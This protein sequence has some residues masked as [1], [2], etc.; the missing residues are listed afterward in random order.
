MAPQSR[1]MTRALTQRPLADMEKDNFLTQARFEP[2]LFY[3]KSMKIA[4]KVNLRKKTV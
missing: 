4:T 3:P 1:Q 2:K